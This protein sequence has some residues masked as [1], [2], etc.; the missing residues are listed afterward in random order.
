VLGT[1]AAAERRVSVPVHGQSV[2]SATRPARTGFS[3]TYSSVDPRCR[4]PL[5]GF[6]AKRRPKTWFSRS[7]RSLNPRAYPPFSSRIPAESVGCG[8]STT[9]W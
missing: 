5:T 3:R 2:A 4:S 8:V 7:W 9:R 6:E 1:A